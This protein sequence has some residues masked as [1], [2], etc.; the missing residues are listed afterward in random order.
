MVIAVIL[1]ILI[2]LVLLLI[3]PLKVLV[4]YTEKDLKLNVFLYGLKVF[5]LKKNEKSPPGES[6]KKA[7]KLE[8][9]AGSLSRKLSRIIDTC[10]TAVRLLEKY[11]SITLA[12]VRIRIGTGDAAI[13]AVSTGALWAAVYG[14][15]GVVGRIVYIDKHKVEITPD[16]VNNVFEADAKCIIKSRVVYII[17]IAITILFKIKPHKGEEE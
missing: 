5:S 11:V 12:E 9:D 8:K 3:A 10:K 6:K 2:I 17:I 16:Y 7:E 4:Q 14:M 15:L 1:V 13:T